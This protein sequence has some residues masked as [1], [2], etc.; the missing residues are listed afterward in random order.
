M[1]LKLTPTP[2]GIIIA[3]YVLMAQGFMRK[4]IDVEHVSAIMFLDE[5][6][7][8]CCMPYALIVAYKS[9]ITTMVF[10]HFINI[11]FLYWFIVV[12]S[13]LFGEPSLAQ[14]TY[15][16]LL[17]SKYIIVFL[18][19]YGAYRKSLSEQLFIRL[20]KTIVVLNLPFVLL[21]LWQP[22]LY[23]TM[24]PFG[25]HNGVFIY[26]SGNQFSRAAGIFWFTGQ[27]AM[28]AVFSA[29]FFLIQQLKLGRQQ[30][31]IFFLLSIFLLLS[32]LSRGEIASF[33]LAMGFTYLRF[34]SVGKMKQVSYFVVVVAFV[35][36]VFSNLTL[37]HTSLDEVLGGASV[38]E[39]APRAK[40][41]SAA[42]VEASENFPLGAG[43][44]TLGGHAAVVFDSDLFYKHGFQYTWYFERGVYLTDTFWPKILAE[45]GVLG[46]IILFIFFIFYP[47]VFYRQTKTNSVVPAYTFFALLALL[48]NSFSAPVYNSVLFIFFALFFVGGYK[49]CE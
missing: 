44:G 34:F 21:Q 43:L 31:F 36:I 22:A 14:F 33:I 8:V 37:I 16:F 13:S 29:G 45:S 18:Y 7:V 35:V 27:L 49:K 11:L 32:T 26:S 42:W 25:S 23:N 4:L 47:L 48:V 46:A 24:F 3:I 2:M 19:C 20:L 38:I 15:Q 10:R 30:Y 12:L 9:Y 5:L 40:M 1:L 39:L 6:I 28:F 17:D 41:M